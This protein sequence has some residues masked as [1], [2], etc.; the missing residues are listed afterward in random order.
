[1]NLGGFGAEA[2]EDSLRFLL[3]VV[4]VVVVMVA[5]SPAEVEE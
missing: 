3:V 5:G 2:E 4:V 1:M